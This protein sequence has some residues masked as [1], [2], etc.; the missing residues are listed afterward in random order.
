M[1]KGGRYIAN[2][3]GE[4]ELVERTQLAE[5]NQAGA[6]TEHHA[7]EADRAGKDAASR[8]RPK[9]GSRKARSSESGAG[10]K[11]KGSE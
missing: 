7:D 5:A 1:N 3:A 11:S 6:P 2:D 10:D 4:R 8:E 9:S